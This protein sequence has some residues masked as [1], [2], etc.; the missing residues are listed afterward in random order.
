MKYS[1]TMSSFKEIF[2]PLTDALPVLK[3]L[4]YDAVEFIGEGQSSRDLNNFTETLIA[5]DLKVS[6]VTGMW[7]NVSSKAGTRRLLSLDGSMVENAKRY[8]TRCIELCGQL[9]GQQFNVC[10]FADPCTTMLDFSHR[11]LPQR[12]KLKLVERSIPLLRSLANYAKDYGVLL[13]LEPDRK[14]VV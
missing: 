7:G 5:H 11:V 6:G 13:L 1:V 2:E 8:V 4:N 12:Q 10:L 9:G 14:S 3:R